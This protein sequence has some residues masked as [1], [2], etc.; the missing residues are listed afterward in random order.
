MNDQ[1]QTNKTAIDTN[2]INFQL[3]FIATYEDEHGMKIPLN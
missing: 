1:F 3:A 2:A